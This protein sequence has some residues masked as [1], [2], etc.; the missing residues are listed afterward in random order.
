MQWHIWSKRPEKTPIIFSPPTWRERLFPGLEELPEKNKNFRLFKMISTKR[1][2]VVVL[3]LVVPLVMSMAPS[4]IRIDPDGGYT[5]LVIRIDKDVP[6]ELCP[7]IL[8]NLQV[9]LLL[10]WTNVCSSSRLGRTHLS[11]RGKLSHRYSNYGSFHLHVAWSFQMSLLIQTFFIGTFT[12]EGCSWYQTR[13]LLTLVQQCIAIVFI[14][15]R[16]LSYLIF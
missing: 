8:S 2:L 3:G 5:G 12:K 10:R 9:R 4:Q 7:K 6:E 1:T 15:I 14:S 13:D 11:N 16:W